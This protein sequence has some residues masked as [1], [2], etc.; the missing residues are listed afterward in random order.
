M[1]INKNLIISIIVTLILGVGISALVFK[2]MGTTASEKNNAELYYQ[3]KEEAKAEVQAEFHNQLEEVKNETEQQINSLKAEYD[4]A[5]AEAKLQQA[6]D[7]QAAVEQA[8][9]NAQKAIENATSPQAIEERR[10]E[11]MKKNPI[12][13]PK[14]EYNEVPPSKED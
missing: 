11:E 3:M 6:E 5:I 14:T 4:K 7:I 12:E 2:P 1:R 10:Q 13:A 8:N 9:A